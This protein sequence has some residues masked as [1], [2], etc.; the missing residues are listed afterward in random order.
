MQISRVLLALFSF[1]AIALAAPLNP[2]EAGRSRIAKFKF[3]FFSDAYGLSRRLFN[4]SPG[5]LDRR[6]MQRSFPFWIV[7]YLVI[8]T[9]DFTELNLYQQASQ[10]RRG[11]CVSNE[12][13][14][15][16]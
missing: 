1:S 14:E 4:H 8:S 2:A 12:V 7:I 6:G 16:F 13:I 5:H 10:L 9:E 11:V 15:F 3:Y